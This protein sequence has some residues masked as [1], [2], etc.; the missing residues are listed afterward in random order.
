VSRTQASSILLRALALS[1]LLAPAARAA[2]PEDDTCTPDAL[3]QDA[4][5]GL[6]TGSPALQRYLRELLKEAALVTPNE[7]LLRQLEREDDAAMI[8]ALGAALAH[9]AEMNEDPKLIAPLLARAMRDEDPARRAAAVR[10]LQGTGSVELMSGAGVD[11]DYADLIKD[12]APA[13]RQAVVDNLVAEDD[14]VYSGHNAQLAEAAFATAEA[15]SDKGAAARIVAETSTEGIG[16]ERARAL[17]GS[18]DDDDVR[19][20]VAAARAL[21]GVPPELA[22]DALRALVARYRSDDAMEV[23]REILSSIA[24]L[25]RTRAI[26]LLESLR[27]V[28]ARLDAEIDAWVSVLKLGLPEWQLVVREKNRHAK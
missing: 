6:R 25:E 13:V 4:R 7:V 19:M 22:H 17:G 5:S 21:G 2:L 15:A 3:V 8:E 20:R 14:D 12:D 23:R 24:R 9:K 10:A 16:A 27:S 26:P 18:L 11:V 1:A 28:D